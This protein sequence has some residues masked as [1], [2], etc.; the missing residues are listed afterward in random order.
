VSHQEPTSSLGPIHRL[1][2]ARKVED[3]RLELPKADANERDRDG[4]TPLFIGV[5]KGHSDVINLL[6]SNGAD[7][8]AGDNN[9]ETALH[10]AARFF[11]VTAAE[12]LLAAGASVG[13]RDNHGNSP[14]F[15]A[16][17]ESKGRGELIKLLLSN[18]ADRD[19]KN[20]HGVSPR[21]LAESIVNYDVK[22]FFTRR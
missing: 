13:A 11:Q 6:L 12:Q 16:V 14:L 5:M 7:V 10:F 1:V 21:E 18:G 4:R 3:R 20:L 17:F 22:Q 19:E 2:A 8:N 9:G 15:R